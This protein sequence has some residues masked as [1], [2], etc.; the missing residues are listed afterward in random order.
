M[1][2]HK[3]SIGKFKILILTHL[4]ISI[5]KMKYKFSILTHLIFIRLL[6]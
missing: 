5:G 4:H 3:I 2:E 6:T 1:K